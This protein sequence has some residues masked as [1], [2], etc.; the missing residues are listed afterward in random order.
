L[1]NAT[2]ILTDTNTGEVRTAGTTSPGY[3]H[4]AE[5]ETGDC[6]VLTVKSKRYVFESRSFILKN[7][8]DDLVLIAQ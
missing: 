5:L 7:D 2:V 3:F 4:F 8:I 6:Y 1:L